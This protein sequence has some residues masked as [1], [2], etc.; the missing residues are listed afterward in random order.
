ML[1]SADDVIEA[2]IDL[3]VP[4]PQRTKTGAKQ[5]G[6]AHRI[7]IG[8]DIF[9]V[10]TPINLDNKTLLEADEVE[11]ESEQRRLA[12]KVKSVA[13]HIPQLK[14]KLRLLRRQRLPQLPSALR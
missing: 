11:V 1:D 2:R 5:D 7:V 9:G 10:L 3:D 13:A 4:E 12:A 8:V 6:V 14:P